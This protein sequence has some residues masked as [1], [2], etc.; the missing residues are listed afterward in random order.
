MTVRKHVEAVGPAEFQRS[1]VGPAE[2]NLAKQLEDERTALKD[3]TEK[4]ELTMKNL[5]DTKLKLTDTEVKL[6]EAEDKL[7]KAVYLS[8]RHSG[9]WKKKNLFKGPP[10]NLRKSPILCKARKIIR[11]LVFFQLVMRLQVV[12]TT[13]VMPQLGAQQLDTKALLPGD[14]VLHQVPEVDLSGGLQL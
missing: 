12:P 13:W 6:S 14:P 10:T 9:G 11:A 3:M 7:S 2:A 5:T 1:V 8:G 4:Y